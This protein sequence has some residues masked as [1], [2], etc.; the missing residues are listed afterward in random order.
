MRAGDDHRTQTNVEPAN[1]DYNI[2]ALN[3]YKVYYQPHAASRKS[4]QRCCEQSSVI[5]L[6]I[7]SRVPL[8]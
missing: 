7:V 1:Y 8:A 4:C 3:P 6:L 2:G 5:K